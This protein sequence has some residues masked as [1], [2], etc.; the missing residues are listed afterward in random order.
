M[1][2]LATL[3]HDRTLIEQNVY[4]SSEGKYYLVQRRLDPYGDGQRFDFGDGNVGYGVT[5]VTHGGESGRVVYWRAWEALLDAGFEAPAPK[6]R[7]K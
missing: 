3:S 5:V 4:V 1:K 6:G 2:G 7:Q